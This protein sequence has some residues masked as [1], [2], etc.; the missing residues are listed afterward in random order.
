MRIHNHLYHFILIELVRLFENV[1]FLLLFLIQNCQMLLEILDV[2][3]DS[4][5][6]VFHVE[7]LELDVYA[8]LE[9][10]L[11]FFVEIFENFLDLVE[12]SSELL[13]GGSDGDR[14]RSSFLML[15]VLN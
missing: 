1:L 3:Q 15:C 9:E 7:F 14:G 10:D 13:G 4:V 6:Y 12:T 8:C 11:L 5:V 2:L